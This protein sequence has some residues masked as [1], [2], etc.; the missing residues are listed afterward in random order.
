[1]SNHSTVGQEL[2]QVCE[3]MACE[4]RAEIL[5]HLNDLNAEY[6]HIESLKKLATGT[7]MIQ[8]YMEVN[9]SRFG[10]RYAVKLDGK[11]DLYFLTTKFHAPLKT[12]RYKRILDSIRDGME[13]VLLH[14]GLRKYNSLE[15]ADVNIKHKI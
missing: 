3:Q 2:E 5:Q 13:F 1:M 6:T 12:D 15:Y 11:E 14:R 8:D 7:Y 4:A 10:K 9:T